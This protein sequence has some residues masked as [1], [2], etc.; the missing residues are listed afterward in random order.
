MELTHNSHLPFP[1]LRHP[2]VTPLQP[3]SPLRHPSSALSPPTTWRPWPS[4]R[5]DQNK[6]FD[7]KIKTFFSFPAAHQAFWPC[8]EA[9]EKIPVR[10][11]R[12]QRSTSLLFLIE[13][14]TEHVQ[15]CGR[16]LDQVSNN[17]FLSARSCPDTCCGE[18]S[19]PEADRLGLK[20]WCFHL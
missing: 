2:R 5:S 1:T 9:E 15:I 4:V 10:L 12:M 8:R 16:I 18:Q 7:F 20:Y 3:S 11:V 19:S 13:S 14:A 17:R 6:N